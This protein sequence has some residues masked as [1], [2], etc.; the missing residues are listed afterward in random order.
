MM[1]TIIFQ[2]GHPFRWIFTSEKTGEVLKKNKCKLKASDIAAALKKR[3]FKLRGKRNKYR[4][5]SK[6]ACV[7]FRTEGGSM[8]FRLLDEAE[9]HFV[10]GDRTYSQYISAIQVF[11][12]GFPLKGCGIFE[13]CYSKWPDRPALHKTFEFVHMPKSADVF[14]LNTQGYIRDSAS[15]GQGLDVSKKIDENETPRQERLVITETQNDILKLTSCKVIKLIEG[16][17]GSKITRASFL[18]YFNTAWTP[19]IVACTGIHVETKNMTILNRYSNQMALAAPSS[20]GKSTAQLDVDVDA[21]DIVVAPPQNSRSPTHRM[22]HPKR[23]TSDIYGSSEDLRVK[24]EIEREVAEQ[25]Q[26]NSPIGK[27]Q[28]APLVSEWVPPP[29]S[30]IPRS[31]IPYEKTEASPDKNSELKRK[32]GGKRHS[33]LDNFIALSSKGLGATGTKP[34]RQKLNNQ[35]DTG[36]RKTYLQLTNTKCARIKGY[37]D[38]VRGGDSEVWKDE[39]TRRRPISA[40]HLLRRKCKSRVNEWGDEDTDPM[41]EFAETHGLEAG[42]V[43]S[44][45]L[46][47]KLPLQGDTCFGDYCNLLTPLVAS[48]EDT[49]EYLA[50]VGMMKVKGADGVLRLKA[51]KAEQQITCKAVLLSRAESKFIGGEVVVIENIESYEYSENDIINAC[52]KQHILRVA[53]KCRK[54]AFTSLIKGGLKRVPN[55]GDLQA[56]AFVYRNL[57]YNDALSQVHPTRFYYTVPCCRVCAYR[58]MAFRN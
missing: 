22:K 55:I 8:S 41:R 12:E 4:D 37:P 26:C 47:K 50:S 30:N 49:D 43:R 39:R 16:A 31:K 6:F 15:D 52:A 45:G 7:W 29:S 36:G 38:Q 32:F 57:I 33:V 13:H 35:A 9:L 48:V 51:L 42:G 19:F 2:H 11:F 1:D 23:T 27:V 58:F 20:K 5:D 18:F 46:Q 54:D 34:G 3:S 28:H 40:P 25:Q 21:G 44:S 10:L 56:T 24:G 53:E 17:V 14:D